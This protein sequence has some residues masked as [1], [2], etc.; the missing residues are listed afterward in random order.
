MN[1]YLLLFCSSL[2]EYSKWIKD[3]CVKNEI[4]GID[5]DIIYK[6]FNNTRVSFSEPK[7][8]SVK[9]RKEGS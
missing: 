1:H 9:I 8:I 2:I 3:G 5:E 4:F 7:E 6:F